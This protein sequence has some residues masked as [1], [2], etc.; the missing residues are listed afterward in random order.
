[1]NKDRLRRRPRP[2][3]SV[4]QKSTSDERL[5]KSSFSVIDP[6][7]QQSLSLPAVVSLPIHSYIGLFLVSVR[8]MDIFVH[9]AI[10]VI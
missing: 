4:A 7:I 6:S 10:T 5:V 9:F 2:T 8:S 1:M 3:T